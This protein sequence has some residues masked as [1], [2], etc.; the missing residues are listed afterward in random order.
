MRFVIPNATKKRL[1]ALGHAR[2]AEKHPSWTRR[3]SDVFNDQEVDALGCLGEWPIC[4]YMGLQMDEAVHAHGDTGNDAVLK[5]GRTLAIKFNHRWRGYLIV[6]QRDGDTDTELSDLKSDFIA[7]VHGE[8]R[9]PFPASCRCKELMES[10]DDFVVHIAGYLSAAMFIEL[11]EYANWG[12]GGRYY[13]K[14]HQLK[15]IVKSDTESIP[16]EHLEW[17]RDYDDNFDINP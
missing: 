14:P 2:N 13:V 12:L 6:E 1:V 8:C 9:P 4:E 16:H 7:L 10:N 15:E 11:K 17:V 3:K 5:D